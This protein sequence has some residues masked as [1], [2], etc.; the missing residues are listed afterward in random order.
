[1]QGDKPYMI[2][3][4]IRDLSF[5]YGEIPVLKNLDININDKTINVILFVMYF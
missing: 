1:M 3:F 4:D 2:K 5:S